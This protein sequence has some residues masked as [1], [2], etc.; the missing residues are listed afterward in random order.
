MKK[1][2]Y[3]DHAATTP[4]KKEVLDEM[5]PYF[6]EYYGNPSS[7]YSFSNYSKLA[8]DKAREQVAKALHAKKNEIYFNCDVFNFGFGGLRR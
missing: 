2:V 5:I 1:I 6:S 8:I 4:V 3:M 7:V